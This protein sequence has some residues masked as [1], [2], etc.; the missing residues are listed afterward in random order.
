MDNESVE[1]YSTYVLEFVRN[2]GISG[3]DREKNKSSDEKKEIESLKTYNNYLIFGYFDLLHCKKLLGEDKKYINYLSIV[4]VF[5]E[6]IENKIENADHKVANKTLSLYCK[7]GSDQDGAAR[8]NADFFLIQDEGTTLSNTPF[9]GVIQ[10]SLCMESYKLKDPQNIEDIDTFLQN[11]EKRIYEIADNNKH[12]EEGILMYRALF[13]SSTTGDFCLVIRT[14]LIR[15]IYDIAI[16]LNGTQNNSQEKYTMMTYTN[17]G[18]ECKPLA[19]KGYATLDQDVRDKNKERISLRFSADESI[20][21]ELRQYI[22]KKSNAE[23]TTVEG[24][25]GRYEYLLTIGMDEFAALYPYLCECK[26]GKNGD[27]Q[28]QSCLADIFD[29]TLARNINER[30]LIELESDTTAFTGILAAGKKERA[31]REEEKKELFSANEELLKKIKE[32]N[33][34]RTAFQEEHFAFQDLIRGTI[35]IY[36]SFSASGMD[37]ESYINWL[38]FCTDMRVLCDCILQFMKHYNTWAGKEEVNEQDKKWYRA[39]VLW[40]WRENLNAIN[41]YT[42]LVQNI[43]YQ[44]YQSPNYEIQTSID[45]EKFMVAYREFMDLYITDAM[46]K[47]REKEND[48]ESFKV[49]PLIYPNLAKD[50]VS[51]TAPFMLKKPLRNMKAREIICTVPSFEYFARLYDLLPWIIHE[52]SHHLR[53]IDREERNKFV[54]GYIFSYIFKMLMRKNLRRLSEYDLYGAYYGKAEKDIVAS[55][56]HVAEQEIFEQEGFR[57][58]NFEMLLLQI[59]KWLKNKFPLGAE[60]DEPVPAEEEENLRKQEYQF[61]LDAYRKENELTEESLNVILKIWDNKINMKER[62]NLAKHLLEKYYRDLQVKMPDIKRRLKI[63]LKDIYTE[64]IMERKFEKLAAASKNNPAA[65]RNYYEQIIAVYRI[66]KIAA[67]KKSNDQE[68][69]DDYFQK[70]FDHFQ[71]NYKEE[72]VHKNAMS[73][74]ASIHMLRNLGLLKEDSKDFIKEMVK[75]F[76]EEDNA[77]IMADKETRQKI[78][79][80]TYAD[81]IMATSLQLTGFGYCRLVLQTASDAKLSERKYEYE[82]INYERFRTV[83]AVLLAKPQKDRKPQEGDWWEVDARKLIADAQDYCQYMIGHIQKKFLEKKTIMIQGKA[84]EITG[85]EQESFT[86][87]L[88]MICTQMK[89]YIARSEDQIRQVLLLDILLHGEREDIHPKVKKKWD[90]H[91]K[92]MILCDDIRYNFWRLACFCKGIVNIVKDGKIFVSAKLFEHMQKIWNENNGRSKIGCDWE[93]KRAFLTA[94]KCKVGIFY[95]EPIQVYE[96]TPDLKLE[97]TI[98]F[99][100]NYYYHNRFRV[101]NHMFDPEQK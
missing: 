98:E 65:V 1:K 19:K 2:D 48:S 89:R 81:I 59:D 39:V 22:D 35:E 80:E 71:E 66:M 46:E 45:A 20:R 41:R 40:D 38:M 6:E 56:T 12:V 32:I 60:Y 82:D 23:K 63:Y 29:K 9:L 4:N 69:I 91:K 50:K 13:R 21:E 88:E 64:T 28:K 43:N 33:Q 94:P 57:E 10:I 58:F 97:N 72:I 61:W 101:V 11:C 76:R 99:I 18:I 27:S 84:H 55:M 90:D 53:L 67:R 68:K 96:K 3:A 52:T 70:V 47:R 75:I 49:Y 26:F 24:L 25:F 77:H 17:V 42:T 16:A 73:N 74:A 54:T 34:Y 100:Q 83:A 51:V 95:N 37:K 14:N 78:Y 44:T 87:L 8:E 92:V 79:L 36:N 15:Q 93:E 86:K 5:E 30:M 85:E 31:Q 62:Q 7:S